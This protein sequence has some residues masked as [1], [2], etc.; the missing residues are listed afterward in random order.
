LSNL[1]QPH[2][3]TSAVLEFLLREDQSEDPLELGLRVRRQVLGREHVDRSMNSATDLTRDFQLLITRYAWGA[4]WSRPAL[5][6]RTRRLLVLAITAAMGRWEEF[7]LHLRAALQG[8]LE[9]C[10]L[11]EALLQSAVYAG[12][13]AANTGFHIATEEIQ[14]LNT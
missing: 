12:V 11:K 8:G 5:D 4:V 3:F 13:P 9:P 2:S 7:R 6:H 10:D 14:K 1:S